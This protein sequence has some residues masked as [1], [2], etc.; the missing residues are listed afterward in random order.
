MVSAMLEHLLDKTIY[1]PDVFDTPVAKLV[2]KTPPA[3][4]ID[5]Q[6]NTTKWLEELGATS[7]DDIY[8]QVQEQTAREAF[9]VLTQTNDPKKQRATLTKIE[10]PEAV[11]H[12]VGML[13]AYDWHFVEQA[14]EI[15]GYAVAKLMEE[16][17]HPDARIRLR[18]LEMLGKVTEVALFTDR[19]EVKKSDMSDAELEQRI[20]DKLARITQIVEV[21]DVIEITEKQD[22]PDKTGD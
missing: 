1:T 7:D 17:T 16:T 19:V 3:E 10:T 11:K 18:A 2:D 6:I 21:T 13:T 14:K 20:K 8:D 22:E 9:A 12:L 4:I 15:R 5:A